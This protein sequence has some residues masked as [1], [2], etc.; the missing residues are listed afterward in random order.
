MMSRNKNRN[1]GYSMVELIIVMC[2]IGILT[3]ASFVTLRSVDSAKYTKAVS[4]LESEMTTLRTSTMAQDSR[5]AM[6]LYLGADGDYY[7][8][9]GYV[10]ANV[11]PGGTSYAFH[12]G[13]P[14]DLLDADGNPKIGYYS[15][16]G[17][18]NPVRVLSRGTITYNGNPVTTGGVLIYYRKS[19]GSMILG[20]G[21]YRLFRRNGEMIADVHL[22]QVTGLYHETY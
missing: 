7:I 14:S 15:Y 12:S 2:I 8:E 1:K 20:G 16:S 11:Q 17:V 22:K 5:M 19:D 9:R 18:S 6:K 21:E 13:C 4:T 3:A 10:V